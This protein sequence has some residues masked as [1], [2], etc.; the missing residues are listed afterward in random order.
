M[1]LKTR[2][3]VF[4]TCGLGGFGVALFNTQLRP[5]GLVVAVIFFFLAG[6][7]LSTASLIARSLQSFVGK[8][9]RAEVWGRPLPNSGGEAFD[10][11]SISAFGAGLL[12]RLRPSA[13]GRRSLLKVAQ[14]KS[15]RVEMG[16]IEIGD[17]AYVS[18]AGTKLQPARKAPA[19]VLLA[20]PP[21]ESGEDPEVVKV[22]KT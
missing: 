22:C 5:I 18:W 4:A 17:A 11:V 12:I 7:A 21:S 10:V 6:T 9:V 16:R 1:R 2:G 13:G 19:T 14:P 15:A 3:I 20:S 8:P